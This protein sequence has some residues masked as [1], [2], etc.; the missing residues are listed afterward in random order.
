MILG[1]I[2]HLQFTAPLFLLL[3]PWNPSSRQR[4]SARLCTV[5]CMRKGMWVRQIIG[6]LELLESF[7][8]IPCLMMTC[9]NVQLQVERY[10]RQE[11]IRERLVNAFCRFLKKQHKLHFCDFSE[12]TLTVCIQ[13][14]TMRFTIGIHN[15]H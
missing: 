11:N 10:W 2:P 15:Y 13:L 12:M 3:L 14:F 7:L 9:F 1:F 8:R 5:H 6:G 4:E